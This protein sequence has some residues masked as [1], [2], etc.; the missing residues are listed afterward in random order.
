MNKIEQLEELIKIHKE[1]YYRGY[2]HFTTADGRTF[3]PIS[4]KEFDDLEKELRN[5][6]PNNLLLSKVGTPNI[7][8]DQKFKHKHPMMSIEKIE[9]ISDIERKLGSD[10]VATYKMDGSACT[11]L[12]DSTNSEDYFFMNAITRGDGEYG[13]DITKN[14]IYIKNFP[15]LFDSDTIEIEE[16]RGEIVISKENFELLKAEMIL[17]NLE[18]PKRIRNIVSGLLHRL[19][20][21]D[22]CRYL[23]FIAYDVRGYNLP[24]TYREILTILDSLRFQT[25][26]TSSIFKNG[27]LT[28]VSSVIE[29]YKNRRDSFKYLTDGLVFRVNDLALGESMGKTNH[30]YK[31][32]VAYKLETLNLETP[33]Q[34]IIP[35]V[36]RTG[37]ISIVGA[38]D[39]VEISDAIITRVTL[40][41]IRCVRENHL[42][43]GSIIEITRSK[44]VIPKFI[45]LVSNPKN[46]KTYDITNCP[47]CNSELI[48]T[49]SGA[50][51]RCINPNC[52]DKNIKAMLHFAKVLKIDKLSDETVKKIFE[53]GTTKFYDLFTLTIEDIIKLDGFA[54][55]SATSMFN[56]IQSKKNLPFETF[57]ISLGI[58]NVGKTV[59]KK[60]VEK[61]KTYN[62][63]MTKYDDEFH[64]MTNSFYNSLLEMDDVGDIIAQN[65]WDNMD[66]IRWCVEELKNVGVT[67]VDPVEEETKKVEGGVLSGKKYIISGSTN[68]GKKEIYEIINSLGGEQVSTVKQCSVLITNEKHG[69]YEEAVKYNKTIM[70]EEEFFNSIKLTEGI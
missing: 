8:E 36:N 64:N 26:Q 49:K 9:D 53:S 31:H 20:N 41:N 58:E 23:D 33:I 45:R 69:K 27:I 50:D 70:S 25:P 10:L 5:L 68:L 16:V 32:S 57:L 60:I 7:S 44:E 3:Y 66:Y 4:D 59:S 21:R 43:V 67:I 62:N 40:H 63:F 12:Y 14:V 48:L 2:D 34:K 35:E 55:K 52:K 46:Q 6:D 11:F 65:I 13:E 29:N 39:P 47:S 19:D 42:N 22:L 51:L 30:H 28:S 24:K 38:V 56:A 17:R 54:L 61:Y 18:E 15:T 37:K 1:I